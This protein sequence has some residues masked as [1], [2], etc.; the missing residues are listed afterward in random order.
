MEASIPFPE[1]IDEDQ[2]D[3]KTS[4]SSSYNRDILSENEDSQVSKG[5]FIMA[6]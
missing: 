4:I 1:A 3:I 5:M 2:Y 6:S